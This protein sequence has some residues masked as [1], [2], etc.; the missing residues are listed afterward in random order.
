M[1]SRT[2]ILTV[3]QMLQMGHHVFSL[4]GIELNVTVHW[5]VLRF[6][7]IVV[8]KL[9]PPNG[10]MIQVPVKCPIRAKRKSLGSLLF[11]IEDL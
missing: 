6:A 10:L 8:N 9:R 3:V 7:A 1:A 5:L 4:H 11:E 2:I